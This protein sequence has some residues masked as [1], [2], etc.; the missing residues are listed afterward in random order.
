MASPARAIAPPLPAVQRYFE[1]SLYLLVTVSVLTVVST[2]KLDWAS[3]L[4][5]PALLMVKGVRYWRGHGPE[6]SS[7]TATWLVLAYFLFFPFD[8]WI[9]SRDLAAGAP[10]PALYGGLLAAMHLMLFATF[11]RL[12][13]ARTTRDYVFLA[14]LAFSAMLASAILTVDTTFLV[15]LAVFLVLAISTFVSLE[16][17][18]SSEGAATPPMESGSPTA[19][20]LSRALGLTSALVAVSALVLGAFFFFLI[21]RFTAGYLSAL[22]PQ[23]TL[24]SGFSENVTLGQIGE[25]KKSSAVVMRVRVTANPAG[26]AAMRWRGIALTNFDGKRWFNPPQDS[27]VVGAAP[28]GIYR[29]IPG[30]IETANSAPLRYTVLLEPI[31]TDAI[32][33]ASRPVEIRGRFGPQIDR[34]GRPGQHGFLLLDRDGSVFNPYHNANVMRYEA[35][36]EVPAIPPAKLRGAGT[37]YPDEMRGVYLQLPALDPRIPLLAKQVT[38][39]AATPYDKAI[40][41]E[42][43]FRTRFG[44]T[45]DLTKPTGPDPLAYFLFERKAGHC[46]YFASAMTVMLRTL[47]IPSRYV[48]GFLPGEFN[49]VASDYIVRGSDAHSWVEAYFPGYGWMTFDPTPPS[50]DNS[51]N[52]FSTLSHYWDWFEFTWSEWVINYDFRH[53][54]T[55][56]ENMQR[57]TSSWSQR[58]QKAY[59]GK[60]KEILASMRHWQARVSSSPYSLPGALVF[61]VAL[62]IFV[63]GRQ[64]G[65][66]LAARWTLRFR[67]EGQFSSALAALEYK[68]MLK[69]LE[70]RG[71]RKSPGQTALEFAAAIPSAQI[72]APVAQLTDL[73]QSARFG[74]HPADARAMSSLLAAIRSLL[75]SSKH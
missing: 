63:R 46:E 30:G 45:L 61:L 18:R 67:R 40:T 35:V 73:Y 13:S 5:P 2:G 6:L 21:P 51:R 1:I 49:D 20:R 32:F 7:R 4:V 36:S 55:L 52:W 17:R 60:R 23:P 25:I 38:A 47:G 3:L 44:Y 66:F 29:L 9:I 71:W 57:S 22:S 54:V 14:M 43:F 15:S 62:L 39:R 56:W 69:L 31:A 12:F 41:L 27:L 19:R 37:D 24:I 16:I 8:L 53:Q 26:I 50:G 65:G 33:L 68:Q 48:N 64:M 74:N 59:A 11:V 70:R 75:R 10:N 58:A 28:D 34:P 42:V 72:A